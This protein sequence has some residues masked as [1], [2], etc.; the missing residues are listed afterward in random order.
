[1]ATTV[2]LLGVDQIKGPAAGGNLRVFRMSVQLGG[3]YATAAK[4]SFNV[5]AQLQQTLVSR[6]IVKVKVVGTLVDYRDADGNVYT[7]PNAAIALSNVN[8]NCVN[9][10]VT[11]RLDGGA[12]E[13]DTGVEVADGT[14]LNGA[15]MF[16]VIAEVQ[17]S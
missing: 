8:P 16:C 17:P 14:A 5:L 4:P 1:M 7:A 11:F 9:D 15:I 13:G 10:K 2:Q 3:T 6:N 12:T